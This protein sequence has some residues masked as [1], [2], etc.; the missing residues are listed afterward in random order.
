MSSGGGGMGGAPPV[1][2][3]IDYSADSF[4]AD[5]LD[6]RW[7]HK[8]GNSPIPGKVSLGGGQLELTLGGP[9]SYS[10][11]VTNRA[12]DLRERWIGFEIG[13]PPSATTELWVA[14]GPDVNYQKYLEFYV[15]DG[16]M[17]LLAKTDTDADGDTEEVTLLQIPFNFAKH[18]NLR[19]RHEA[20][21]I[22]FEHLDPNTGWTSLL[23]VEDTLI[24]P[25]FT[26]VYMGGR[27][28]STAPVLDQVVRFNAIYGQQDVTPLCPTEQIVDDFA[29]PSAQWLRTVIGSCTVG[30]A[31]TLDISCS[32]GGFAGLTARTPFNL[33]GSSLSLRVTDAPAPGFDERLFLYVAPGLTENL[34]K[35]LYLVVETDAVPNTLRVAVKHRVVG[36]N[37]IT[38]LASKLFAPSEVKALRMRGL[39]ATTA[40]FDVHN[41]TEWVEIGEVDVSVVD[42]SLDLRT[43]RPR[44]GGEGSDQNADAL[45]VDDLNGAI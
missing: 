5:D 41:G 38:T 26:H 34:E 7:T 15:H 39:S 20:G 31:G 19:F 21:S 13:E 33:V 36:P 30:T 32:N 8:E 18:Q 14:V 9:N 22:E 37:T 6:G 2:G 17:E 11:I 44:I 1:C 45:S 27:A 40:V 25:E 35:L 4:D 16:S 29:V 23:T 43:V 10:E 3:V 42:P 12:F 28:K 24:E